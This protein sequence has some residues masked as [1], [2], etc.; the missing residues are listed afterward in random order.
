MLST[1]H[2]RST[3]VLGGHDRAGGVPW[4]RGSLRTTGWIGPP[5]AGQDPRPGR[6]SN[7]LSRGRFQKGPLVAMVE[8][9]HMLY[10]V[11]CPGACGTP[12]GQRKPGVGKQEL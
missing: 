5:T 6:V 11:W 2:P 10:P 4:W 7:H 12:G 8:A 3:A 1:A 9:V